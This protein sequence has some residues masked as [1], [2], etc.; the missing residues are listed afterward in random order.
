MSFAFRNQRIDFENTIHHPRRSSAERGNRTSSSP[1]RDTEQSVAG[2]CS[3]PHHTDF[4]RAWSPRAI[5]LLCSQVLLSSTLLGFPHPSLPAISSL[6]LAGHF[7][8]MPL[9]QRGFFPPSK[10]F[11]TF[12]AWYWNLWTKL[13]HSSAKLGWFQL[14]H[15]RKLDILQLS[16]CF[17]V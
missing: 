16:F 14:P 11:I 8:F 6:S 12:T 7:L 17:P 5:P 15:S 13:S 10:E 1:P 4:S 3:Y 9:N 2:F